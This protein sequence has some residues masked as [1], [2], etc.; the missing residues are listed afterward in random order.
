MGGGG[1]GVGFLVCF[2]FG[3]RSLVC[4]TRLVWGAGLISLFWGG[5]IV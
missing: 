3:A 4:R 2:G 1:G 5:A